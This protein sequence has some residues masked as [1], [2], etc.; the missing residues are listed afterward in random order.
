MR[1]NSCNF[2]IFYFFAKKI[3]L[4]KY[5][6]DFTASFQLEK[7]FHEKYFCI[8][9][10]QNGSSLLFQMLYSRNSYYITFKLIFYL[11]RCLMLFYR[12]MVYTLFSVLCVSLPFHFAYN[13]Q[14]QFETC[15]WHCRPDNAVPWAVSLT[16]WFKAI[17]EWNQFLLTI[18]L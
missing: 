14:A 10:L 7:K 12:R 9:T 3:W 15:R 17:S 2:F 5:S 16:P 4:Q 1:G 11:Q 13:V 8:G 18:F 6:S